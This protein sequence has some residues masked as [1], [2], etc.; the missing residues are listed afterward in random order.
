MLATMLDTGRLASVINHSMM[1]SSN[2]NVFRVTGQLCGEFTGHRWRGALM[3]FICSWRN[4]WVNNGEA[5][6]Y[7]R[8]HTNRD[9][10]VMLMLISNPLK[11]PTTKTLHQTHR[12]QKDVSKPMPLIRAEVVCF[13]VFGGHTNTKVGIKITLVYPYTYGE[14]KHHIEII[15]IFY[16]VPFLEIEEIY[17]THD[18]MSPYLCGN[19]K[20]VLKDAMYMSHVSA[21]AAIWSVTSVCGVIE[22]KLIRLNSWRC[23]TPMLRHCNWRVAGSHSTNFGGWVN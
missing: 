11:C 15:C 12:K 2:W 5:G 6:D 21:L 19:L 22:N 14:I 18:C 1:T 9:V 16:V 23:M 13:A 3:F 17:K 8:H 4:R 7:R 10:T 20:T